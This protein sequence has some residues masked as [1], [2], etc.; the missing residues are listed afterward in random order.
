MKRLLPSIAL[1]A[2]VYSM[3][4]ISIAETVHFQLVEKIILPTVDGYGDLL[5]YDPGSRAIYASMARSG[6]AVIDPETNKIAHIINGGI[7]NPSGMAWDRK[8][9]YWTSNEKRNGHVDDQIYV[10]SKRSWKI[11]YRFRPEGLTPDAIYADCRNHRLYVSMDDS[12]WIDI[13]RLT[14]TP[15]YVGKIP[16][17]PTVGSGPDVGVLRAS[18]ARLY[19]PDDSWEEVI[20]LKLNKIINRVNTALPGVVGR[21]SHTKGQAFDKKTGDL[22]VGTTKDG[23]LVLQGNDLKTLMRLPSHSG[24]DE[25]VIDPKYQLVYAFESKAKGFDVY[26]AV[27]MKP[28]AFVETGFT[29]TH[30]GTVNLQSH[31]VYAYAG[32]DHAIFVYKP[33]LSQEVWDNPENIGGIIGKTTSRVV[34]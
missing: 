22:W 11:V 5:R 19:V 32:M 3:P 14:K 6:G 15:S 4:L 33:I 20:N 8:Y 24:I 30:T 26:N 9:I 31:E 7:R 23:I 16:L 25:V 18:K 34:G 10:I 2:F 21:E 28:I 17:Y 29:S 1:V 13:Y 12:N 27:T